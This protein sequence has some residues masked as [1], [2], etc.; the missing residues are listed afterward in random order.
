MISDGVICVIVEI[1]V[2]PEDVV[3]LTD[4]VDKVYADIVQEL[5][6]FLFGS[7]AVR[8]EDHRAMGVSYFETEEAWRAAASVI[9]GIREALKISPGATLAICEYEVV[10]RRGGSEATKLFSPID[11]PGAAA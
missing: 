9:E 4:D 3:R 2:S 7:F 8:R 5:P 6:G 1:S 11:R 10:V